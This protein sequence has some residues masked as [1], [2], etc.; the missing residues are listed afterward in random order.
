[1]VVAAVRSSGAALKS[2]ELSTVP[3][4]GDCRVIRRGALDFFGNGFNL[5]G[6]GLDGPYL[7]RSAGW[8]LFV[9]RP[10]DL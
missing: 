7:Y 5:E 2:D 1:M 4:G 10:A 8:I 9:R 3:G 6:A